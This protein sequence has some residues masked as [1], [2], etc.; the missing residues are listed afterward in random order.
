MKQHFLFL[1]LLLFSQCQQSG[2]GESTF[3]DS[4]EIAEGFQIE[5]MAMEPLISDPVDMEIDELGRWYVV[6]MHG[7]P[8]D[9][10]GSGKVKRLEDTDGDGIPDA[11]TVFMD[12]LVL[13]TGIMRWKQGFLVTD[14][15]NVLYI[16]DTNDDGK[17]DIKQVLLTGFARSNPQHNVNNPIFGIDNWI[18][19]SHEGAVRSKNFEEV[20]GDRGSAVH[21]P[22]NPDAQSLSQNANGLTVRFQPD[23]GK[24]E[25]GASRGQFGHTFDPYGHHFL[26]SNADHLFYEVI[27]APYIQ[28]NKDLLIPNGRTY[29]PKSGKGFEIYP[30]TENPNHQL[31]TDVGMITSACG[32]MWYQ[33]GIF[34]MEYQNAIFTAE[35]V[36]NMVHVDK[37][38]EKG[39][40]FEA[41]NMLQNQEFLASKDSWFRPV[42]HYVGPDGAI[43]LIDYYR[44][45]IEHPEW[46]S[47]EVINSGDLYAGVNQGRIYRITPSGTSPPNF[48][49][50][51]NLSSMSDAELI[52]QLNNKNGWW[53]THAQRLLMERNYDELAH[54][55]T[56]ALTQGLN[57]TG[58]I[59]A[60][61][62]LSGKEVLSDKSL[63][64]LLNDASPNVREQAIKV[65]ERRLNKSMT[66]SE[67]LLAMTDDPNAKVR[68]QLLLTL[69]E[70]SSQKVANARTKLLFEDIED[71]WMQLAALSAKD[72]DVKAVYDQAQNDLLSIQT[73]NTTL[74][75]RRLSEL[76]SRSGSSHEINSFLTS[77]LESS[78]AIWYS[79]IILDGISRSISDNPSLSISPHNLQL[80]ESKFDLMTN[81]RIRSRSIDLLDEAGYFKHQENKLQHKAL[82]YIKQG[83]AD[84]ELISDALKVL[85]RTNAD[86]H[87]QLFQKY[88]LAET[89]PLIRESALRAHQFVGTHALPFLVNAWPQLLPDERTRAVQILT[90]SNEGKR[91]ILNSIQSGKIH[92]SSISW[93][94]T[95]QL[96]NSQNDDIRALARRILSGNELNADSIWSQYK[97]AL[98]INGNSDTGEQV[99]RQ[100]CGTCHQK[101]NQNGIAFGPDLASVQNRSL[102]ALLLDIL[103]PNRSIADGYELWQLELNNGEFMSGIIA[104]ES[105][106]S[107]T[108]RNAAGQDQTINRSTIKSIKAFENSAMPQNLYAQISIEEMADLLA[109]L[110][111]T[112]RR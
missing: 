37:V 31:L 67:A 38:T 86:Q 58:K 100:S 70:L 35:P 26:T 51:L 105:P 33:G 22:S 47:D 68:Y 19:L 1:A 59:H 110:K 4:F 77:T 88:L 83:D 23:Q 75:F 109:Y 48:L 98:A 5:L 14:P 80:L 16:E 49:D 45:V 63:L 87:L 41:E 34:P 73:P 93:P 103:H 60:M 30:I 11:S 21:F 82:A 96:L 32:I 13:P 101:S 28:R 61:W 39:A 76:I 53:R 107:M 99:F 84:P 50:N 102:S 79:P 85:A 3:L 36:H 64:R 44:K 54:S 66:L 97:E 15:P 9:L 111:N 27:D 108:L 7:Y 90:N 57:E 18:Y 2:R 74:F 81:T 10:S 8:L 52:Q 112:V 65:T 55:I 56:T 20:L 71:E 17:A 106:S 91:L 95:V 46:L 94:K 25:T 42:N 62:I 12:S 24:L 6:E 40:S 29:I 43:Y 104:D 92:P 72:L 69:G 89:N 78:E